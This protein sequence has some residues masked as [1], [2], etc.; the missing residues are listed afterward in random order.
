MRNLEGAQDNVFL[1]C[2]LWDFNWETSKVGG[3]LMFKSSNYLKDY[4]VTC[5]V[6]NVGSSQL[7]LST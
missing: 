6:A 5:L 1:L 3:D 2:D 4:V 7:G